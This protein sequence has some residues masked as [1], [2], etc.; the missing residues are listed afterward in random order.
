MYPST[1]TRPNN[2]AIEVLTYCLQP[3]KLTGWLLTTVS[4]QGICGI[5]LA[6]EQATLMQELQER[7]PQAQPASSEWQ[8]QIVDLIDNGGKA[9]AI[10]LNLR[11]TAFQQKVWLALKEIPAGQTR[12]YRQLASFIG[13]PKAIRAVAA[14]CAANPIAVAVPCHRVI[15]SDGALAGYYWGGTEVKRALLEREQ[16]ALNQSQNCR[17]TTPG[18]L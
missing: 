17:L 12:T 10:P 13:Q 18:K 3:C 14:A 9:D 11:G 8:S 2:R 5:F 4:P 6:K 1:K 7:F 16:A 15:R